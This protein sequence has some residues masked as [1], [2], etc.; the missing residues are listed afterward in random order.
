MSARWRLR[1]KMKADSKRMSQTSN[2]R[3][4]MTLCLSLTVSELTAFVCGPGNDDM[5]V[6][7]LGAVGQMSRRIPQD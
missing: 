7:Q 6:C 3:L 5:P 4:V 1:L 2:L